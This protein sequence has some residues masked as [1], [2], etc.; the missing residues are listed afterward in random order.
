MNGGSEELEFGFLT[1]R[2]DYIGV[3][4]EAQ[5]YPDRIYYYKKSFDPEKV[6][7][8]CTKQLRVSCVLKYY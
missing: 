2:K 7:D 8:T 1:K 6:I 3:D 4:E 5:I